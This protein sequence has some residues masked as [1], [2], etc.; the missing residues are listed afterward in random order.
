MT[1]RTVAPEQEAQTARAEESEDALISRVSAGRRS[2]DDR[3]LDV[4]A[5][6][7]RAAQRNKAAL[8]RLAK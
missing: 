7:H 2:G 1:E 6:V 5:L 8:D 3:G 4:D